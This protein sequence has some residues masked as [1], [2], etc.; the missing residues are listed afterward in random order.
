MNAVKKREL[1]L[2]EFRVYMLI[3]EWAETPRYIAERLGIDVATVRAHIYA[4]HKKLG[5]HSAEEM[6]IQYHR[7]EN[8]GVG[9]RWV[10]DS[11]VYA[12]SERENQLK[13]K[14]STKI[15]ASK[16]GVFR[17]G[18]VEGVRL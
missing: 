1:T 15:D 4:L 2:A 14:P 13:R 3:V 8:L 11:E 17:G 7:R 12:I 6:L 9:K 16:Y 10:P 18:L 5:V